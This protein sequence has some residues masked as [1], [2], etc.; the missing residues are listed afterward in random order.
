MSIPIQAS[1]RDERAGR[2]AAVPQS[3]ADDHQ[4]SNAPGCPMIASLPKP[5]SVY[6]QSTEAPTEARMLQKGLRLSQKRAKG[7]DLVVACGRGE[8]RSA[9]LH[10]ACAQHCLGWL[11]LRGEINSCSCNPGRRKRRTRDERDPDSRRKEIVTR[12]LPAGD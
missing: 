8:S 12:T 3:T 2:D 4:V 6:P 5:S 11:V 10:G 7:T 9:M 1:P